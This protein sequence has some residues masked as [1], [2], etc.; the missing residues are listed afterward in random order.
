MPDLRLHGMLR[1]PTACP[2]WGLALGSWNLSA[3]SRDTT[4][5]CFKW[6]NEK[7]SPCEFVKS[8]CESGGSEAQSHWGAC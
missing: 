8:T 1:E 4:K 6:R 5:D 3:L 7:H 2:L